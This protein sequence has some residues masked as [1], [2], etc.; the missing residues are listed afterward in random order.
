MMTIT[1]SPNLHRRRPS[2]SLLIGPHVHVHFLIT[3]WAAKLALTGGDRAILATVL[4]TRSALDRQGPSDV[5]DWLE[6]WVSS[7]ATLFP[8][9]LQ[10]E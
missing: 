10:T 3:F 4:S 7:M 9:L 1:S 2:A 5:N 8:T 6:P